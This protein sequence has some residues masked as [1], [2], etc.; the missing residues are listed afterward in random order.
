MKTK[1]QSQKGSLLLVTLIGLIVITLLGLAFLKGSGA[2]LKVSGDNSKNTDASYVADSGIQ[3]VM[4]NVK[5][6]IGFYRNDVDFLHLRP[7][8]YSTTPWT[9]TLLTKVSYSGS[10]DRTNFKTQCLSVNSSD[11]CEYLADLEELSVGLG[12]NI[13]SNYNVELLS[14]DRRIAPPASS[15]DK[16]PW[17]RD[18]GEVKIPDSLS[19][20]YAGLNTNVRIYGGRIKATDNSGRTTS[21][22]DFKMI[23]YGIPIFQWLELS[24]DCITVT[25]ASSSNTGRMHSNT[26]FRAATIGSNK[27]SP[28]DFNSGTKTLTTSGKIWKISRLEDTGGSW[29]FNY[30]NSGI[31]V[32]AVSTSPRSF[33]DFQTHLADAFTTNPSDYTVSISTAD[34]AKAANDGVTRWKEDDP[35]GYTYYSQRVNASDSE[36][37]D[38]LADKVSPIN[39]SYYDELKKDG[40][41]VSDIIQPLGMNSKG[42]PDSAYLQQVKKIVTAD[43]RIVDGKLVDLFGTEITSPTA[44]GYYDISKFVT[45]KPNNFYNPVFGR[46]ANITEI[47]VGAL[48]SNYPNVSQIYV[49]STVP[50]QGEIHFP[51]PNCTGTTG[52]GSTH[53]AKCI[54][55]SGV[56]CGS[57]VA[58]NTGTYEA[59]KVVNG[60]YLP[61][62]GLTITTNTAAL[63]QGNY[64]LDQ[65]PSIVGKPAAILSD[66]IQFLSNDWDTTGS[67]GWNPSN[68][69]GPKSGSATTYN[70][71]YM[72]GAVLP[73]IEKWDNKDLWRKTSQ[74]S[75]WKPVNFPPKAGSTVVNDWQFRALANF[76][77]GANWTTRQN[78]S[79]GINPPPGTD[80]TILVQLQSVVPV[81]D[82][83]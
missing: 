76:F 13:D 22:K 24:D 30:G 70:F 77:T 73:L 81:E 64:N 83:K 6:Q 63:V 52:G 14:M 40:F 50:Q 60:A 23:I 56:P 66:T 1:F 82:A 41:Q 57:C 51:T 2:D 32:E 12:S 59:V 67:T 48:K 72:T 15:S 29:F 3:R 65:P 37:N 20:G 21:V 18:L 55:A 19:S 26:C 75:F 4:E 74:I 16:E 46:N 8:N 31:S 78:T 68:V 45:P 53:P 34:I 79:F 28:L 33:V 44:S 36:F 42:T 35:D 7:M 38:R 54:N 27:L 25:A 11:A 10:Y 62:N 58:S 43:V 61:A 17:N 39:L 80:F 49:G 47:D 9:P 5:R 71:A 69:T